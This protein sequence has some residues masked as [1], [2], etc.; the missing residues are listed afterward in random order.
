VPAVSSAATPITATPTTAERAAEGDA[1]A[2][3]ELARR[4]RTERT[5]GEVMALAD[6]RAA[7]KRRALRDFR[8]VLLSH[9]ELPEHRARLKELIRDP[10]TA[11]PALALASELPGSVG[12]DLLYETWV[13][14]P[15]KTET[16]RVAEE[17][18]FSKDVYEA[19][20]PALRVALDL[21][22]AET[23]EDVRQILPRVRESGD[24]RSTP[25]LLKLRRKRGCGPNKQEDCYVCLRDLEKD[26]AAVGIEAA[27]SAARRRPAPKP[28]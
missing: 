17:L 14:T 9:P 27:L 22:I 7:S 26:K 21:R 24:S 11:L 3:S 28:W 16:T 4:P 23:C 2:M 15:H 1:S 6:G 10:D 25:L 18:V 13:G 5:V 8:T 19:A 20:P 12:P